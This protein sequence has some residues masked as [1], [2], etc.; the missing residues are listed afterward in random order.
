MGVITILTK[1]ISDY[2]TY[3]SVILAV[4]SGL[5]LILSKDYSAGIN[6]I[7]Q[8]LLVVFSGA[9]AL[10]IRLDLN[11]VAGQVQAQIQPPAAVKRLG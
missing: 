5:G 1:L 3:A 10:S 8:A 2:K 4:V 9:S 6:Q 7:L 11:K